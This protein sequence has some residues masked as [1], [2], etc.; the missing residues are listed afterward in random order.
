MKSS[1]DVATVPQMFE[2]I[3]I[4]NIDMGPEYVS[5]KAQLYSKDKSLLQRIDEYF[6]NDE[7][8]NLF[9]NKYFR[10]KVD[11]YNDG[12][13]KAYPELFEN[14]DMLVERAYNILAKKVAYSRIKKPEQ[15]VYA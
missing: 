8:T 7:V 3:L 11:S 13:A 12:I 5:F 14:K 4:S 1:T 15:I 9:P 10:F 2:D 6:K